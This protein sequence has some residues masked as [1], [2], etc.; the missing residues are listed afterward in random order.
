[1][2]ESTGSRLWG[3]V[4]LGEAVGQTVLRLFDGQDEELFAL[5]TEVFPRKLDFHTDFRVMVDDCNQLLSRLAFA[6]WRKTYARLAPDPQKQ[7]PYP[8]LLKAQYEELEKSMDLL[9]RNPDQSFTRRPGLQSNPPLKNIRSQSLKAIHLQSEMYPVIRKSFTY[10][11][12]ANRYV[13]HRCQILLQQMRHQK[14]IEW[15]QQAAQRLQKRLHHPVFTDLSPSLASD[16]HSPVLRGKAGYSA[17]FRVSLHLEKSLKHSETP[18][19]QLD[20][21]GVAQLYEIWCVSF[22]VGYLLEMTAWS[23]IRENLVKPGANG[24]EMKLNTGK[25]PILSLAKEDQSIRVWYQ[26]R[27]G[28][29]ENTSFPQVP[30]LVLE[31]QKEGFERPF[32]YILDAKYRLHKQA[33]PPADS[34][35]QMHRYRD[36]ILPELQSIDRGKTAQKSLGGIVLFPYPFEEQ[37]FQQ[38]RFYQNVQRVGI[39]A[40]PLHPGRSNELFKKWLSHLLQSSPEQ[41]DDAVI[42]YERHDQN[43]VRK[44]LKRS[45]L[46][47]ELKDTHVPDKILRTPGEDV[48]IPEGV[49]FWDT[50]QKRLLCSTEVVKRNFDE[51]QTKWIYQLSSPRPL[52]LDF[53]HSTLMQTNAHALF[54]CI[55]YQNSDCLLLPSYRWVKM[56]KELQL[57]TDA[58][59]LAWN[60]QRQLLARFQLKEQSFIL[61]SD[62]QEQWFVRKEGISGRW[63]WPEFVQD[64]LL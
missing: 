42:E 61:Q 57:K 29:T 64:F 5:Q 22:L 43:R 28:W 32:L 19:F 30:D 37:T 54:L 52:D 13:Y 23:V 7:D 41:L 25:D 12:A 60:D 44:D 33:G 51:D 40:I 49:I 34:I 55:G 14:E 27:F 53:S 58:V 10:D 6:Q 4:S 9:L 2:L 1:M 3:S 62:R 63:S 48:F 36:A 11:T 24:W 56:W 20:Y 8:A 31:I 38:H 47:Q 21:K 46:I 16:Q 26:R 45:I 39:G 59:R 35:A 50:N 18:F 15:M 17:F